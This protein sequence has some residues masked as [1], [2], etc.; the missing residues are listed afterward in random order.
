[1]NPDQLV[2]IIGEALIDVVV[3]DREARELPG[4]APLNVAVTLGR[5]GDLV[6]I[7]T[8]I[9]DDHRGRSIVNHLRD[10]SV[11]L[12]PGSMSLRKTS[13]A[14][15]T[16]ATDGAAEYEFAIDWVPSPI[17]PPT[18]PTWL[19]TG[20]IGLFLEPGATTVKG[21]AKV[22]PDCVISIDPNIRPA[23]I[24]SR[25]RARGVFEEWTALADVVKLSDEDASWLYPDLR[26]DQV[27]STLH[28][29]GVGLAVL[30]RGPQG[31]VLSSPSA[32]IVVPAV[33]AQ[34]ID[35]IGAGDSYMGAL[36]HA[37]LPDGRRQ[38]VAQGEADATLLAEIGS[39]AASV[40]AI[41]VSRAGAN[42][43]WLHD[44]A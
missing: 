7:I 41:T 37:C 35:T 42:P 11:E 31:S 34:V 18:S 25:A 9:A 26:Y 39:F 23:L 14:Q 44:L 27:L 12:A 38:T 19:H 21:L 10:S 29:R 4:G 8:A 30:T 32:Q 36:I 3:R 22:S 16:I 24:G 13:I 28:D 20:S 33:S 40:A 43:P 2:R 6:E 17:S 5:L 15:A 1:V